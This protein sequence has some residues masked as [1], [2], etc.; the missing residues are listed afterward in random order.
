M[1]KTRLF[2]FYLT[3]AASA[4]LCAGQDKAGNEGIIL[5]SILLAPPGTP[6]QHSVVLTWTA[7]PTS[8]VTYNIYRGAAAGVCI[9]NV[10]P[11][12][13][14]ITTTTFTDNVNLTDGQKVFYNVSAAKG[15]AESPCD[16]ELQVLIPVLPGA[17]SGLS[18]TVN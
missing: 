6:G 9:G 12:A 16:G 10:T 3:L 14:G 4:L 11:Y 5:N 18:G 15:G 8:G 17:P 7:S 2:A 13:T 1:Q